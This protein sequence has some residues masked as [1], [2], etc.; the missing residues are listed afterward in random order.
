[1][2]PPLA[3]WAS[4]SEGRSV[5]RIRPCW[6]TAVNT[7]ATRKVGVLGE[8]SRQRAAVP[9]MPAG[10]SEGLPTRSIGPTRDHLNLKPHHGPK[11]ASCSRR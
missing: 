5:P 1:M 3:T 9:H 6:E 11:H 8:R 4:M 7:P 10:G 2:V